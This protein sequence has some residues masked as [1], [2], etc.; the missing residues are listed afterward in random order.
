MCGV[1]ALRK[2]SDGPGEMVSAFTDEVRGFG[3]PMEPWELEG[4]N[5]ARALVGKPPLTESPGIRYLK[6][7]G[8]EDKDGWWDW[9]KFS[10]Q[11]DDFLD[12]FDVLYPQYQL[13][14][15]IDWSA[16][17]AKYAEDALCATAMSV[18]YGGKQNIRRDT[19]L[20]AGCVNV[21]NCPIGDKAIGS[22][23]KLWW[24]DDQ[25]FAH[26]PD[27]PEGQKDRIFGPVDPDTGKQMTPAQAPLYDVPEVV[28]NAGKVIQKFKEGYRGKAKG[29]KQI[30]FERGLWKKG[31]IGK[32]DKEKDPQGRGEDL[33]M[34]HVLQNCFDFATEK[35]AFQD[36]LLKRGHIPEMSP[37][38]HPEVAGV[39]V[40]YCWGKAKQHFRRHTDHIGKHLHENIVYCL[41][42]EVQ[43]LRRVRKYA[44]KARA[45]RRAYEGNTQMD[46]EDIEKHVKR[47]KSHRGFHLD[48]A[49]LQNN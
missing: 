48:F 41:S 23:Q 6:Y 5:T 37:K 36:M 7:G 24:S 15:E 25:I 17:H 1:V 39:G 11:V 30:L 18:G 33:S 42:K 19:K 31:M 20:C 3:F 34:V 32:V 46:K 2:K 27:A 4:V 28:D 44:R 26:F 21:E 8:G 43:P 45:Y 22:I 14:M 12:C 35:T 9:Q 29:M 10:L 13:Q 40:E 49:W 47:Q 16:G 38:C